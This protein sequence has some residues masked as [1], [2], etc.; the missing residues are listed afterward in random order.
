MDIM[1]RA[2]PATN[3]VLKKSMRLSVVV[4]ACNPSY[5]GKRDQE[6]WV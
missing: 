3:E 2:I 5:L 4:H 1:L 6:D